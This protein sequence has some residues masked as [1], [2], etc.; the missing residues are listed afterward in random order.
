MINTKMELW[1]K[2]QCNRSNLEI[3]PMK[4]LVENREQFIYC[5]D[6]HVLIQVE[7]SVKLESNK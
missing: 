4:Q 7:A 2:N 6:F 3:S 1:I 5:Y